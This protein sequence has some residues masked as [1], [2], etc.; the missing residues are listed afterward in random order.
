ML[1][2]SYIIEQKGNTMATFSVEG[3]S[4]K[5]GRNT[6]LNNVSFEA[7]EGDCIGIVG[8]NGCGKS[9]LMKI[10]SNAFNPDS[11][12]I[13]YNNEDVTGNNRL[14]SRLVGYVPQDNPLFDNLSVKDNLRLRYCDSTHS[15]KKDIKNGL[16]SSFGLTKYIHYP[17]R[18]LSG[19][20]KKRLSIVCALA[21]D[22]KILIL[23]EPGA[24]LDIQCKEDIKTHMKDFIAKGGLIII[25]SHEETELSICNHIMLMKDGGLEELP[26]TD[27]TYLLERLGSDND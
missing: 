8:G 15:L 18:K 3:I 21:K 27:I 9:T 13:F 17:V 16:V 7:N 26:T 20:M 25:V 5:Y 4:K 6:I 2:F 12:K 23:D 1:K 22:P 14:L 24:S 19:G 11:G 10:L